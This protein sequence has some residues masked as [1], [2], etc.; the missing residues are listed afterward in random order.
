MPLSPQ[1][2]STRRARRFIEAITA[3]GAAIPDDPFETAR[4]RLGGIRFVAQPK[5]E[6]VPQTQRDPGR[7]G[8]SVQ[9]ADDGVR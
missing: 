6:G 7:S 8:Y 3:A 4:R 5:G 1:M 9:R 2:I